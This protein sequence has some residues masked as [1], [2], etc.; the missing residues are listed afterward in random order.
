MTL[1][2]FAKA[3]NMPKEPSANLTQRRKEV[4]VVVQPYYSSGPDGPNYKQYCKQKMILH[5][6]FRQLS[7]LLTGHNTFTEAYQQLLSST[8]LPSSL[9]E[10]VH[11]LE[12]QESTSVK[13]MLKTMRYVFILPI[14]I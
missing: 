14:Y 10:D 1:L 4:V 3:Y 13:M 12:E 6:A 8:N 2:T 9:E 7:D 11:I 5:V